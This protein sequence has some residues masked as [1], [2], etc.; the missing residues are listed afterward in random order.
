MTSLHTDRG[1]ALISSLMA[2]LGLV[3]VLCFFDYRRF[4]ICTPWG[5]L[6]KLPWVTLPKTGPNSN[7]RHVLSYH[8]NYM[9][10]QAQLFYY[11]PNTMANRNGD[12]PVFA[13][14]RACARDDHHSALC[15]SCSAAHDIFEQGPRNGSH[16][17]PDGFL[18]TRPAGGGGGANSAPLQDFLDT[19]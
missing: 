8:S 9:K 7:A 13:H 2:S 18:N 17:L 15:I 6:P 11:I 3:M 12:Q 16:L 14:S 1:M 10:I 5:D 19:S 4:E